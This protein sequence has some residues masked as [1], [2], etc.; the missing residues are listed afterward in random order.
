MKQTVKFQRVS[1]FR[2]ICSIIFDGIIAVCLFVL[3]FACVGHPIVSSTTSYNETY[4]KY[5]N[6][7]TSTSLYI[8]YEEND[9]VSIITN[10]HD[11]RITEFCVYLENNNLEVKYKDDNVSFSSERYYQ[12][13]YENS[14]IN[15]NLEGEPLFIYDKE[16]DIY[17]DNIYVI[18]KDGN[19]TNEVDSDKSVKVRTFYQ[20]IVNDLAEKVLNFELVKE[21]T[22]KL[23]ALTL[24][25]FFISII[26]T[27]LVIY[28]LIPMITHDGT[29]I[30]KKMLQ[31]R[32]IDAKNGQNAKKFQL[33]VRFTFFTLINVVLGI[34]TYGL[35]IIISI[36]MMFVYKTRQT[37]HDVIS[38][39]MVVRNN[40]GE[41][42]NVN[43]EDIISITYDDGV[44]EEEVEIY[45]QKQSN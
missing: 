17:S 14:N 28:L 26:P 27:I 7:L 13:K 33:F 19:I 5:N 42:E 8:Y 37:I 15:P 2:R 21:Y 1:L 23:T 30:G 25:M 40:F 6:F 11:K 12:I 32:V 36:F 44:I 31:M 39:T 38:G 18:D 9:A 24:L 20:N 41:Q 4:E 22:Q 16:K 45:E 3:L 29:T 10:D 43:N 34:F 35:S